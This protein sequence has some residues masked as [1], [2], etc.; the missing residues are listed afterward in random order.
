[1]QADTVKQVDALVAQI[2]AGSQAQS[3]ALAELTKA[4]ARL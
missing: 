4:L 3:R 1:L 2:A